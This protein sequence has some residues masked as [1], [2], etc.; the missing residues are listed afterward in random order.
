MEW[1]SGDRETSIKN[2]NRNSWRRHMLESDSKVVAKAG[3]RGAGF[4]SC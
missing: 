4:D 3:K 1:T 2:I